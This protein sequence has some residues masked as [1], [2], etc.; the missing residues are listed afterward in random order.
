MSSMRVYENLVKKGSHCA[1]EWEE[2]GSPRSVVQSKDVSGKAGGDFDVGD[3]CSV[4]V[5]NGSKIT[6]YMATVLGI[7]EQLVN[8]SNDTR[9]AE[10]LC[11]S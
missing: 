3:V 9:G 1:V 6:T 8:F 5:R 11:I 7:G 10:N 4:N 2:P